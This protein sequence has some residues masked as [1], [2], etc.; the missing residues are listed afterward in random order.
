VIRAVQE[1]LAELDAGRR[2]DRQTFVADHAEIAAVLEE[3]LDGLEFLRQAAPRLQSADDSPPTTVPSLAS[4]LEGTLGDF[5]ILHEAGRGGMGVVYEAVQISLSRRVALKVLPFAAAMDPK[6]LQRFKNE[7]QAAAHLQHQNIVPVYGVG[8]E[9]GVHFYA[10]QYIDG[11]TLAAVIRE[12]R[13]WAGLEPALPTPSPEAAS[14]L[15]S[16]LASGRWAP[17]KPARVAGGRSGGGGEPTGPYH[18]TPPLPAG[19]ATPSPQGLTPPATA[20]SPRGCTQSLGFFRTVARLGVQTAEALEHAHQQGVIHRD[21]KPANLLL[22]ATG[23]LW[24]TD[25]GLAKLG[26][27][28]GLTLS[29]DLVGTLRYMSPEQALTKRVTVDARTDV[30]SLGVTLYELLALEPAYNGRNREEVLRQITFEE[31]RPLRRLNKAVP[32]ELEL[33]L[34]K[35]MAK[36]PEERY[37]TAHELAEDLRRYLEDK[38]IQAKRPSLRQRTAKWA[39]RHK[40]VVRAAG[41]VLVLAMVALAVST[42]L[43]WRQAQETMIAK[44]NAEASLDVAYELL[45]NIWMT[46]AERRLPQQQSPT[47]EDRQ[48]LEKV[49]PHFEQLARQQGT[50]PRVR[51]RTASAYVRLAGIQAQLGQDAEAKAKYHQ[52]LAHFEEL[53]TAYPENPSYRHKLARCLL[54]M[55]DTA[56]HPRYFKTVQE[57]EEAVRRAMVLQEGLVKES[58]ANS[59]FRRDLAA[60]Y[61]LVGVRFRQRKQLEEAEKLLRPALDIRDQL[62][63]EHPMDPN[64]RQDLGDSLGRMGCLLRD[65]GRLEAAEKLFRRGLEVR[66]K[67][68]DEYPSVHIHRYQLGHAFRELASIL[69]L[70][71]R[72]QEAEEDLRQ[73][74]A[75]WRKVMEQFPGVPIVRTTYSQSQNDLAYVL[76]QMRRFEEGEQAYAQAQ[77]IFKGLNAAF[78]AVARN[79]LGWG[80]QRDL[81]VGGGDPAYVGLNSFLLALNP[82]NWEAYMDRGRAYDRLWESE[83]AIADYSMALVLMPS[84]HKNR[85]EVLFQR[86]INYRR[87][88]DLSNAEADLHKI[89]ELDLDVDIIFRSLQPVAAWQCTNLALRYITGPATQQHPNKALPLARKAVKLAPGN[90]LCLNTLGLVY[91]RLGNYAQAMENLELSL[92]ESKGEMLAI[93]LF[94]LAMCCAREGQAAKAK[95]RY[96]RAVHCLQEQQSKLHPRWQEELDSFQAEAKALLQTQSHPTVDD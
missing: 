92:R 18:P 17:V 13:Q 70:T 45:E 33:I 66:Q 58:P 41:V 39:R 43:I 47:P 5:R 54:D 96:Q 34:L 37:V 72:L 68:V 42:L 71:G 40:T 73:C 89:A 16:E 76:Q 7:A 20:L 11:Q 6:Q 12:L 23:R 90:C 94:F 21:I 87:L 19:S 29:G 53:A 28:A 78:P 60:S 74:N 51:Q 95:D 30:Y 35:A 50:E 84:G 65:T 3:C 52:A 85:G 79:S 1:Y 67:I 26:S 32:A 9:R 64:Y 15:A 77:V 82:F 2:P 48:L 14:A 36:S 80:D 63:A 59:D 69:Q 44:L 10:M 31:P 24:I 49:L 83:K 27:E 81:P 62:A 91:Y 8:C 4:E 56:V 61:A 25:F 38:P 75:V 86:N 93:N 57:N 88:H 46:L 22:D 55:A